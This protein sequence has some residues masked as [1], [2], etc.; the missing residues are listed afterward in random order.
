MNPHPQRRAALSLAFDIGCCPTVLSP[1][2]AASLGIDAG[3]SRSRR[4]PPLDGVQ[5]LGTSAIRPERG[6]SRAPCLGLVRCA[7]CRSCTSAGPSFKLFSKPAPEQLIPGRANKPEHIVFENVIHKM[8]EPIENH[9]CI[10]PVLGLSK[11]HNGLL[12]KK[13]VRHLR[14]QCPVQLPACLAEPKRVCASRE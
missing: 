14:Q 12:R 8:V 7:P 1:D 5:V 9:K 11:R 13:C 6:D 4:G 10:E 3:A 2:L